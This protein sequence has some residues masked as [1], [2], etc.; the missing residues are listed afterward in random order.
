MDHVVK[1][2]VHV[3]KNLPLPLHLV[4]EG[5]PANQ[6]KNQTLAIHKT[7][8]GDLKQPIHKPF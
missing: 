4:A 2:V 5:I 7:I 8:K 3:V 1:F 6:M